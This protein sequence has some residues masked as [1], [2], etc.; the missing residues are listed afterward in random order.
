MP[1]TKEPFLGSAP[2]DLWSSPTKPFDPKAVTRASWEPQP[3]RPKKK[4]PL[5]GFNRHPDAQA[6]L[7]YRTGNYKVMSRGTK[8]WIVWVRRIQ[9]GLRVLQF[10][11]AAGVLLLMIL[12]TGVDGQTSWALRV[13]SA[14]AAVHCAYGVYHLSRPAGGRTPSSSSAY[15]FFAGLC[16]LCI[17]PI[18]AYGAMA[19]QQHGAE[20]STLL[21]DKSLVKTLTLALF[22]G[23][24][25]ASG[26]HAV[27]LMISVWLGI[28]F[29][30]ITLMPPDMNPLEDNLTSRTRHK[31][32]KS[33]VS[34]VYT[35]Y[36][37]DKR[38]STA[39]ESSRG[40]VQT[41]DDLSRGPAVPFHHTRA[42]SSIS[43]SNRD[44]RLDLP[45]RYSYIA[46]GNSPRN[47][48]HSLTQKR[49]SIPLSASSK[50]GSYVGVPLDD[51]NLEDFGASGSPRS[52]MQPRP[53][54]FTENWTTS[55]SLIGRTQ[56]RNRALAAQERERE[57]R[58]YEALVDRYGDSDSDAEGNENIHI[59]AGSDFEDDP[60]TRS[61]HPNPLGSNPAA[62]PPRVKTP[63]YSPNV[64]SE[65]SLNKRSVSGSVDIADEKTTAQSRV[66]APS[67][68]YRDSSIQPEGA[69][70]SKPY[71]EL[72]SATPPIMVGGG[73]QVS[74]GN[75][76][77]ANP[78]TAYGRRNVSGK[79]VE[80]GRAGQPYKTYGRYDE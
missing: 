30:K 37:G 69:F 78:S 52:S 61:G 57:S 10:N 24:M 73:R 53:G 66:G 77:D 20:W 26:V 4:G 2:G 56:Q 16:D 40:S 35:D 8:K 12:I 60:A 74:S 48:T 63:Y 28:M 71:G 59:L 47:S 38:I 41:F 44:S 32:T 18:Y 79:I 17:L 51:P 34:T 27:T 50:R 13:L 62:T 42:R 55:E 6:P 64:L 22:Y 39:K 31:K 11:A 14:I 76:Y 33:S 19:E 43:S 46:P 49:D 45:S 72:K 21:A 67:Q 58:T 36:S 25:A 5:V 65:T 80:E 75:D 23:L 68:R 29:R 3:K 7:A 70:F 54:R 9:L 15:Q 1:P